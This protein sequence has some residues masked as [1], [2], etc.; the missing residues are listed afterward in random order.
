MK[1]A[2]KSRRVSCRMINKGFGT[3]TLGTKC[4]SSV[5]NN[6]RKAPLIKTTEKKNKLKTETKLCQCVGVW[7]EPTCT[8][9]ICAGPGESVLTHSGSAA[10]QLVSTDALKITGGAVVV[11]VAVALHVPIVW[12]E[13]WAAPSHWQGQDRCE[14][15]SVKV[16]RTVGIKVD[17]AVFS[18]ERPQKIND[19]SFCWGFFL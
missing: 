1:E 12:W 5:S 11:S 4:Q 18:A 13:E 7:R 15:E 14:A 19:F 10:L 3:K 8:G 17:T 6:L 16:L 9:G 2:V